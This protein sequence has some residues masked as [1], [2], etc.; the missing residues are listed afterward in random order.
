M[1]LVENF[2]SEP[3]VTLIKS[4]RLVSTELKSFE[5]VILPYGIRWLENLLGIAK[6]P[7]PDDILK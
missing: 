5:A 6:V 1:L 4:Q 3:M 2:T 7:L